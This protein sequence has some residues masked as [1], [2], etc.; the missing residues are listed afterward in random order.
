MGRWHRRRNQLGELTEVLGGG[1]REKLVSG[2][3]WTAEAQ[4]VE[5]QDPPEVGKE[6]LD[7]LPLGL[8]VT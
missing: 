8:E 5:L 2:A 7:L 4:A 1:G 3:V 6:H